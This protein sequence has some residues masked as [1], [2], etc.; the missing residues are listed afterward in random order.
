MR[1]IANVTRGRDAFGTFSDRE[2]NFEVQTFV[3]GDVILDF[4]PPPTQGW[5]RA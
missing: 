2:W 5:K 1:S 4:A 3:Q